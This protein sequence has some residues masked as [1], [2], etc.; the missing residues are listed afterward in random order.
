MTRIDNN[1]IDS[2]NYSFTSQNSQVILE[3]LAVLS[4]QNIAFHLSNENNLWSI[5]VA[6]ED[7]DNAQK[8]IADYESEHGYFD[9][10]TRPGNSETLFIIEKSYSAL[11]V[12]IGLLLF[13]RITGPENTKTDWFKTGIVSSYEI[14]AGQWWRLITALTLHADFIHVLGNTIFLI[15]FASSLCFSLG[16]G[17]TWL[18]ILLSG[19][20]GNLTTVYIY[21]DCSH[22]A[23]GASTS[24][25]GALGLLAVVM[26]YRKYKENK[27]VKSWIPLISSIGLLGIIGISRPDFIAHVI[28]FSSSA[29]DV[30]A[31]LFGFIWGGILGILCC[32]LKIQKFSRKQTI[33]IILALTA[34]ALIMIAWY[35]ALSL[36]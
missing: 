5:T 14:K 9:I 19:I 10:L 13:F 11:F 33:Q 23:L 7:F 6:E 4:S 31:H 1:S 32:S 25:C 24:V 18:L 17:T 28:G 30:M 16:W 20:L 26:F 12:A 3:W 8:H 35:N 21:A 22:R 15:L 36:I 34:F 27:G 29:T 2:V